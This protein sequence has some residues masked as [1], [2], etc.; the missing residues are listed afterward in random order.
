MGG[1]FGS[2]LVGSDY[3]ATGVPVIRGVNLNHG[4][5]ISGDF[6][7]VSVEK[8]AR[9]LSRNSAAPGDIVYTQ[10]GT[11]GQVSIVP[12]DLAAR[13]VISQSQMRLRVNTD[14]AVPEYVYYASTTNDFLQQVGD[15]AISTGVPHINL[16][17]LS[18][19]EIPLPPLPVQSAIAEVLGALDDKIAANSILA[20]T[21]DR[22]LASTLERLV[23]GRDECTLGSVADVNR[24]SVRPSVGSL[25][26]LDITS[27]GIGEYTYPQL[28]EW[29]QA[30]SRARRG[31]ATGDTVWSTV[32]PNRRSHA[33][34]LD[35]T[36][37]LVASTGLA[38]LS[39]REVGPAYLYE[40]TRR[41]EF[42]NYL[43]NVAEGSAYP[44]VR[45]ERFLEAP[46][47]DVPAESRNAFE[48][49]AAPLRHLLASNARENRTLAATRDA[50]LP[51][52]MSGK[53][54]VRDAEAIAADAGA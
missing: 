1:P 13:F 4:R 46:I 47:P 22:F 38:V 10:R 3:A 31:V 9:D 50:L 37:D 34:I 23:E 43:E 14:V 36:P 11:L 8:F 2:S 42:S 6:V 32:R 30:P 54:R 26:Y 40:A 20:G 17:I 18:Q 16:G 19:L 15:R 35:A 25:R 28:I 29:T 53:L 41:P 5:F 52:L 49:L 45:A 27:V 39:P 48:T 24:T 7:Y 21:V 44:A 51:Q 33:L 12:P